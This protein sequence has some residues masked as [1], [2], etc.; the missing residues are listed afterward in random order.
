MDFRPTSYSDEEEAESHMAEINIV[1]FVDILLVLLVVF[2]V[3]APLS[4]SGI[5]IKMPSSKAKSIVIDE[6]R[7][8]LSIDKKGGYYV[9]KVKIK[10]SQLEDKLKAIF[11][12]R[13]NKDL[14]IRADKRVI[15]GKVVSAMGYAKMA[16]V[17]KIS[18][19]TKPSK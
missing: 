7:V 8:V 9:G 18:M 17:N 2:M 16:G 10:N 19:L 3:A 4:M 5:K 12:Y 15:Y 13:K 6:N 14:Y 1:P 11:E